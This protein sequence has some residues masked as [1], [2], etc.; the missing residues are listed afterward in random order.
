MITRTNA[1]ALIPEDVSREI[2]QE[3][4]QAS[5]V[6]KLGRRMPNIS[7]KK[8]RLP[9]LDVL[10]TAYFV[11]GD[12]GQKQ[13]T[14]TEW[15]NVYLNVEELAVITPIP[16]AVLD[17]ADYDIWAEAKPRIV[18]AMGAAFD[19]AVLIGTNAPSAWPDDI[20]AQCVAASQT[21]DYSSAVGGGSDIYDVLLGEAGIFGLVEADGYDVSGVLARNT[22]KARLRGLRAETGNGEPIFKNYQA[23][24]PSAPTTYTIDGRPTEFIKNFA[25]TSF[26]FIAGDW[27]KLVW[28]LR[29]DISW[30]ILTEA[31]IQDSQ[32][33][34][35]YN[36]AQQDMVALRAVMR[37][38]WAS[39]NPP[40]MLNSNDST[41]LAFAAV[42]P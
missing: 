1:E 17:D 18:E 8:Q 23:G 20:L 33:E 29:Q 34:I 16:E 36:L 13:T 6:M 31:V 11:D 10:P 30:K 15:E 4:V 39:P 19:A 25:Q 26:D 35:I 5:T 40:T 42:I 2:I 9:V 3:V 37:I 38:A 32:G 28:A 7:R 22:M 12:T 21:V 24:G 14:N 27:S 41:R